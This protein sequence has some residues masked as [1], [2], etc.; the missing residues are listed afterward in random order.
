MKHILILLVCVGMQVQAKTF[1]QE[2]INLQLRKASLKHLLNEV[3]KQTLYRFVYHTGTLPDDKRST[4]PYAA[5]VS[6]R[7]YHKPLPVCH[8]IIP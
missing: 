3:E 2:R 4:L 1:A 8:S 7:C 6:I 5:P